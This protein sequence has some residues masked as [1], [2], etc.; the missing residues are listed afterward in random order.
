MRTSTPDRRPRFPRGSFPATVPHALLAPSEVESFLARNSGWT[1]VER[2]LE[3]T[4]D[5]ERYGDALAFV[6]ALGARAEREGHHPRM[7]IDWGRVTV[8]WSTHDA[9][10]VT[11]LDSESAAATE[12]MASRHGAGLDRR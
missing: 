12:A 1:L 10:G 7:T 2:A 5:F 6:V 4:Y 11:S 8:A 9:G 3:R